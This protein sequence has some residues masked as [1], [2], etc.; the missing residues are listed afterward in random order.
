MMYLSNS[1]RV[2]LIKRTLSNMSTYFMSL[3]SLPVSVANHIEKVATRL[4]V[5]WFG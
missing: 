1:G 3:F 4:F 5:G 2:K